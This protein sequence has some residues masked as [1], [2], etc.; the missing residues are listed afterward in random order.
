MNCVATFQLNNH[1][2]RID[3]EERLEKLTE[4]FTDAIELYEQNSEGYSYP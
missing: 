2:D 4:V 3:D 1:L